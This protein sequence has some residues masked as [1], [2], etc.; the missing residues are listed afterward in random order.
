[1]PTEIAAMP[2]VK[3][4]AMSSTEKELYKKGIEWEADRQARLEKSERRAWLVAGVAVLVSLV[5]VIGM[6]T[7]A[8]FKRVVPY[9]FTIDNATGNVELVNAVDDRLSQR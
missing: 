8:P 3:A 4:P 1:M 2:S 9:V 5:A 6:A 7:L